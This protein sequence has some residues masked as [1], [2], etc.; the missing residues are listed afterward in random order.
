MF[1]FLGL[2][3]LAGY[4]AVKIRL[5]MLLIAVASV[6]FYHH[7]TGDAG[8]LLIVTLG[9]LTYFAGRIKNSIL[10]NLVIFCVALSLVFYKY[11]L[12][13]FSSL[14][15]LFPALSSIPAS[16]WSPV[17]APLAISFFVFEFI[18][19]LVDVKD[20]NKPISSPLE[21]LIFA[22]FFPT[23]VAGPIKRFEHFIPSLKHGVANAKLISLDTQV[24]FL[25]VI[26]GFCKKFVSDMLTLYVAGTVPIFAS[27]ALIDRWLIFAAIAF[28]IYLDFSAYS[29][30]AIGFSRMMGVK[31]QENFNW[32]YLARNIKEFWRR[33]HISLSSWIRDYLYIKMGGNRVSPLRHGFNLI[34][35]FVICGLWHGAAWNYVLWGAYHGVGLV[36]HQYF[37]TFILNLK[38]KS[39]VLDFKQRN[40]KFSSFLG[41]INWGVSW[42]ITMVFVWAGWLLFFYPVDQSISMFKALFHV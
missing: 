27:Y 8:I 29:D 22:S 6:A 5:R 35:V 39:F 4:F 17:V 42:V 12:F 14:A 25:R 40:R 32:P 1:G 10:I 7:F 19:Y 33:W 20:G 3:Y 34:L 15:E 31:I 11:T 24:G 13:I 37:E 18:H 38:G 41:A 36:F 30:M 2:Y 21:F 23:L 28:K 9:C 16:E 26:V